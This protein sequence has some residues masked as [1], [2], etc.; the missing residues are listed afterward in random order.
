[1]FY[2]TLEF[3]LLKKRRKTLCEGVMIVNDHQET[4]RN[5]MPFD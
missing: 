1:M 2:D 4:G 5:K 3:R